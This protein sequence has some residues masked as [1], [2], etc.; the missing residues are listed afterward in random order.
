MTARSFLASEA[1]ALGLAALVEV[2][3]AEELSRATAAGAEIVGVN[4]RNLKTLAVDQGVFDTLAPLMPAGTVAVAESGL[5]TAADLVRLG[6]AGYD[7][8]LMSERFMTES[9]PGLA[10]DTVRR[11]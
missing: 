5:K 1:R 6:G 11:R 9:D 4:S 8:F 7:A 10:L 3:D 2:H